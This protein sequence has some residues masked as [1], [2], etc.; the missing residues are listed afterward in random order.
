M[1]ILAPRYY[2]ELHKDIQKIIDAFKFDVFRAKLKGSS[3][4]K[5]QLY[6][7]DYDLLV[8]ITKPYSAETAF[9]FLEDIIQRLTQLNVFITEIKLETHKGVKVRWLYGDKFTLPRFRLK[10][11]DA[12]FVKIDVI[13]RID[14][15]FTEVSCIY[16][17]QVANKVKEDEYVESL[18]QDIKEYKSKGNYYKV[19]KRL[20]SFYKINDDKTNL[21]RLTSF[22]NNKY[23]QVYQET[24]NLEAIQ[25]LKSLFPE[26]KVPKL[27]QNAI[28]NNLNELE[29]PDINMNRKILNKKAKAYYDHFTH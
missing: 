9:K 29:Y 8:Q 12:A 1:D 22:F 19:L 26:H 14:N 24:A 18:R 23:G 21:K 15:L 4:I 11:S 20:F 13:A 28:N 6:Y 27:L 16:N 2:S 5:S 3:S 25:K 10:Y 17:F 7:S